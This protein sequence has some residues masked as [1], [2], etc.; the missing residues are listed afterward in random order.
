MGCLIV[1]KP[2]D[3]N[4]ADRNPG[5]INGILP[6][7]DSDSCNSVAQSGVLMEVCGLGVVAVCDVDAADAGTGL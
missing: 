3:L 1:N 5:I 2:F 4:G 7:R 6:L